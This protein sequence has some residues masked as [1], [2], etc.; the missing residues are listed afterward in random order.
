MSGSDVRLAVAVAVFVGLIALILLAG[1][2]DPWW[3]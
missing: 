2:A 1:W 3:Y